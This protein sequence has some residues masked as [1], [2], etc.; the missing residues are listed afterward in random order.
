M[1]SHSNE[2][3]PQLS[4]EPYA[5][6]LNRRWPIYQ[7]TAHKQIKIKGL[8]APGPNLSQ[9]KM[10]PAPKQTSALQTIL[11]EA[12]QA[13]HLF[14]RSCSQSENMSSSPATSSHPCP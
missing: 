6:L 13:L 3:R 10:N 11:A 4:P 7:S 8:N 5:S 14:N 1:I 2:Q 12:V 9:K